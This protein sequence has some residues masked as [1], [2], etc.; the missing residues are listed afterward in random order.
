MHHQKKCINKGKKD[1]L[2]T[3]SFVADKK[4]AQKAANNAAF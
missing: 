2:L 1:T 3:K 4:R